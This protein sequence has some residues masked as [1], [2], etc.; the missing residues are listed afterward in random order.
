MK[1]LN[2]ENVE[3]LDFGNLIKSKRE[4]KCIEINDIAAMFNVHRRVYLNWEN[5]KTFPINENFNKLLQIL[6][7]KIEEKTRIK[8]CLKCGKDFDKYGRKQYCSKECFYTSGVALKGEEIPCVTCGKPVYKNKSQIDKKYC[9]MACRK[10]VYIKKCPICDT[11]MHSDRIHCSHSCSIIANKDIEKNVK[12]GTT[13]KTPKGYILEKIQVDENT[14][15]WIPQHRLVYE[16]FLGRKLERNENIH[17]LNSIKDDNRLENLELWNSAQPTGQ[18]PKDI[19]KFAREQFLFYRN[20]P[21]YKDIIEAIIME[22][23]IVL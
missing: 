23:N 10:T 13:R 1:M 9:S 2:K 6:D 12:I 5:N 4:E 17:H 19:L 18:R 7:I 11:L 16:K 15:T 8:Q 14:T 21:E 22:L 3:G 20:D